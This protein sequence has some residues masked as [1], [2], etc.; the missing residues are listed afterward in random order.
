LYSKPGSG[1]SI[2]RQRQVDLY[3]FETSLVYR[4]SFRTA[5]ATQ[6]SQEHC[7]KTNKQKLTRGW[8][9][10]SVVESTCLASTKPWVQPSALEK[11][12]KPNK[13]PEPKPNY[14][15]KAC[16]FIVDKW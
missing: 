8:E 14:Y 7:L 1:V 2:H 12:K 9:F 15:S 5:R 16:S 6:L 3:E 4:V 10:S 13:K 11:K